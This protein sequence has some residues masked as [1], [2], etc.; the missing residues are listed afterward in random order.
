MRA[1]QF[2]LMPTNV[3]TQNSVIASLQRKAPNARCPLC[4]I[5]NWAVHDGVIYF[6][7]ALPSVAV[8]CQNC[9]NTHF[10]SLAVATP[11]ILK[12]ETDND[13]K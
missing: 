2:L 7:Q 13:G 12:D 5:S 6:H 9:G 3:S 8:V 11:S 1:L 10:V 4:G